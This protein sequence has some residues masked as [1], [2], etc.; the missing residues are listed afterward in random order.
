MHKC[1]KKET[2]RTRRRKEGERVSDGEWGSVREYSRDRLARLR[3]F[4]APPFLHDS[5][6]LYPPTSLHL[7]LQLLQGERR[8]DV[9]E[10]NREFLF[11]FFP[12]KNTKKKKIRVEESSWTTNHDCR[13]LGSPR[14]IYST[15]CLYSLPFSAI[16]GW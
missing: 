15:A 12:E 7:Q 1:I 13:H 2:K 6:L 3:D 4:R 9:S 10:S 8:T 14:I 11:L 16:V 5:R